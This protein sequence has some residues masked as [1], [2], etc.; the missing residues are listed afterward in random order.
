[1]VL[2]VLSGNF[3]EEDLAFGPRNLWVADSVNDN[4][5]HLA[6]GI[7]VGEVG[8]LVKNEN[9]VHKV[10]TRAKVFCVDLLNDAWFNSRVLL[11][12]RSIRISECSE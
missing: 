2:Y 11:T 8:V 12:F 6:D 7:G 1:M 5:N 4:V 9:E 3:P 10:A